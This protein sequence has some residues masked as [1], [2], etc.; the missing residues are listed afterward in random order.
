MFQHLILVKFM[1]DYLQ[2]CL[3]TYLHH[4]FGIQFRLWLLIYLHMPIRFGQMSFNIVTRS[5]SH[6]FESVSSFISQSVLSQLYS[7]LER[8]IGQTNLVQE[9]YTL[10]KSDVNNT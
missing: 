2:F 9:V 6:I 5:S 1:H 3:K 8:Y 7:H 4:V 10:T